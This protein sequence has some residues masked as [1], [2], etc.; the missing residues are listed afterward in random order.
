[1]QPPLPLQLTVERI[2]QGR[3]SSPTALLDLGGGFVFVGSH[4]GDS[5]LVR[6][7][8]APRSQEAFLSTPKVAAMDLDTQTAPDQ[9][10]ID[11]I[12]TYTNLAPIVDFCVV[13]T[14][15]G[16]GPVGYVLAVHDRLAY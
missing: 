5:L 12:N 2:A 15:S 4:Y 8:Y 16:Q 6:L 14:D 3:F 1:M 13:E 7:T 10:S 11:I 9:T